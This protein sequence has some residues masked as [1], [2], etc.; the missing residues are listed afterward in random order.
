M[1]TKIIK[2]HSVHN[3]HVKKTLTFSTEEN[4]ISNETQALPFNQS[5]ALYSPVAYGLFDDV[6][7]FFKK[8]GDTFVDGFNKLGEG[9]KEGDFNKI[10]TGIGQVGSPLGVELINE[11]SK[12]SSKSP[13]EKKSILETVGKTFIDVAN[14]SAEIAKDGAKKISEGLRER[15][16][17]AK[18]K[19]WGSLDKLE[20]AVKKIFEGVINLEHNH[21]SVDI[22]SPKKIFEDL[23]EL[24]RLEAGYV[25]GGKTSAE[26]AKV[27]NAFNVG[28]SLIEEGVEKGDVEIFSKGVSSIKVMPKPNAMFVIDH[29]IYHN[30][31]SFEKAIERLNEFSDELTSIANKLSE[32]IK[33]ENLEKIITDM[34][35]LKQ[36]DPEDTKLV[37]DQHSP[38]FEAA[39]IDLHSEFIFF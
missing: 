5:S 7:D 21:G 13:E 29:F 14:K 23:I 27:S 12:D 3:G 11:L 6:G 9:F 26:A 38:T 22:G 20:G 16:T 19:E 36:I 34:D 33:D 18:L 2:T 31:E 17:E 30:K 32:D 10:L 35:E 37:N 39:D 1:V 28:K 24:F 8:A 4:N 15:D 25:K